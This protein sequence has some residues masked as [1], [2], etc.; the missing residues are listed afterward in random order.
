M[1]YDFTS[2][3]RRRSGDTPTGTEMLADLRRRLGAF[4]NDPAVAQRI[5]AVEQPTERRESV[6]IQDLVQAHLRSLPTGLEAHP[7]G[8]LRL[9]GSWTTR[10]GLLTHIHGDGRELPEDDRLL[11]VTLATTVTSMDALVSDTHTMLFEIT[12]HP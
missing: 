8:A 11:V 2:S 5:G 3:E 12:R 7:G 10:D 9:I 1:D 4:W 6:A